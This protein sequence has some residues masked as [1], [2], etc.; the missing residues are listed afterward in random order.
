MKLMLL[1]AL[2]RGDL[3][4]KRSRKKSGTKKSNKTFLYWDQGSTQCIGPDRIW[5]CLIQVSNFFLQ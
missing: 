4:C 5:F 3:L 1:T 2:F